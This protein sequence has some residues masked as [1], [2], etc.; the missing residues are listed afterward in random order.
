MRARLLQARLSSDPVRAEERQSF[1]DRMG[2]PVG[3]LLPYDLLTEPL[4]LGPVTDDVDLVLVG[5]SG[6]FGVTDDADWIR[7]FIDLISQVADSDTPMFASCFGFQ[8]LVVGYGGTVRPDPDSSEVGTYTLT[9]SRAGRED[10]LFQALP[11]TF[12]AQEGHKDR[13]FDMPAGLVN[14]AS[15]ERTPFQAA[16]VV[17]RPVYATQ[18]HPELTAAENRARFMR[19]FDM[20]KAAFGADEANAIVD[21]FRDSPGSNDLLR[22]FAHSVCPPSGAT[23]G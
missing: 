1:A 6:A 14:L 20:Y 11:A 3:A 2:V 22:R 9:L 12:P 4:E 23:T 13:A 10:P 19:Y 16:R 8:A 18:F 15:S 7:G 21:A 17:G 5:G